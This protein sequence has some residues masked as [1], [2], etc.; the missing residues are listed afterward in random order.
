LVFVAAT[1]TADGKR[2][3]SPE[4]KWARG[5]AEEF[6]EALLDRDSVDDGVERAGGLV[7]PELISAMNNRTVRD[8]SSL[9]KVACEYGHDSSVRVT[10]EE[11]SP[12]KSEVVFNGVLSGKFIF[13]GEPQTADFRL[14]VAKESGGRW[15]IRLFRIR[16]HA[17]KP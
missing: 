5:V 9:M 15:S 3:E 8:P 17:P 6:W 13:G 1:P 14:R 11:V 10:S 12:D 7:S 16:E 4:V 2:D